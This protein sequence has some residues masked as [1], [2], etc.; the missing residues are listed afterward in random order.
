MR[1]R[2]PGCEDLHVVARIALSELARNSASEMVE[3]LH[4]LV[5]CESPSNSLAALGDC[6]DLLAGWGEEALGRPARRVVRDGLPHLLWEALDPRVVLLGHFD[7]VWPLGTIADWPLTVRD[8]VAS[9]PGVFDMKAGIVQMLTAVELAAEPSRVSILLTCDEETG[10]A[11]S[12]DL[13]ET[14]ARRHRAVLVCEPSADGGAVKVARKGTAWYRIA[15][16]GRASHAGLEPEL[17]V[18]AGIELAHQV[19]ALERLASRA[20]GTTVT[21]TLLSAGTTA[22]T[23]PESASLHVDVRAWTRSEL[24]RVNM[25]VRD[26]APHLPEAAVTVNG[27][28]NRYPFE[29]AM[30][31]PL[32]DEVRAAAEEIGATPPEGVRSGGGSDG[33]FTAALGVP[34][35]DGLGA[36]GAHPH[37]RSEWADVT[38]MPERVALLAALLDRLTTTDLVGDIEAP[39]G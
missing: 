38:A 19:L 24:D 37:A 12:R 7:T 4:V 3:Q 9:G 5:A 21:P 28:I 13:I 25:S 39:A 26:L 36:V 29:L 2:R 33:N 14:Q 10:S 8:G 27:G 17:G 34:T 16:A 11:T 15:V 31:L 32:L 30:G 1:D 23:V 35:L 18:N 20:G 22:N 6:A